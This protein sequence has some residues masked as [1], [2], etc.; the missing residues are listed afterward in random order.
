MASRK[1]ITIQPVLSQ[2]DV[3]TQMTTLKLWLHDAGLHPT[4]L[5]VDTLLAAI[6][7]HL[8]TIPSI[9]QI[10]TD[11]T[12]LG[13]SNGVL[14]RIPVSLLSAPVESIGNLLFNGAAVL[15]NSAKVNLNS[16]SS[17][18]LLFDNTPVLFCSGY[19]DF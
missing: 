11:M 17:G 12:V 8:T 7:S 16:R 19:V 9:A 3:L 2:A 1:E 10:D 5:G 4:I 18:N 15:F 13:V 14:V 6:E